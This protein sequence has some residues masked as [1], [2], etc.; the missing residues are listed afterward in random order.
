MALELIAHWILFGGS[1][2]A[3]SHPP[4]REMMIK[5]LGDKKFFAVYTSIVG[6]S[7]IVMVFRYIKLGRMPQHQKN[8]NVISRF[9]PTP[10]IAAGLQTLAGC[11]MVQS[12]FSP[13]PTGMN[14]AAK[15]QDPEDTRGLVRI[16]R[17]G[18]FAAIGLLSFA[19]VMI[20]PRAIDL[21]FWGGFPLFSYIG[22]LHQDYRQ[23]NTKPAGFY[24]K[25]I[26]NSFRCNC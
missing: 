21:V 26:C 24:E 20:L 9:G 17:H 16:S 5:E 13:S 12:Y 3:M 22:S 18:L 2:L 10:F 4:A 6:A 23:Q 19:Q 15:N 11:M 8:V 14:P 25:N 1:H 7:F